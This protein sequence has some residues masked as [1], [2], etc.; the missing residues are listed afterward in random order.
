M[1]GRRG[2][3]LF[4]ATLLLALV[5]V[6]PGSARDGGRSTYVVVL[7]DS[8]GS[9]PAVARDHANRFGGDLRFIYT[10]ALKGYA[11]TLPDAAAA[12]LAHL[13]GVVSVEQDTLYTADTT[14]TP[15]TWGLDRIDQR[16]RPLSNSYT[17]TNTGAGVTAY[18]VDTGIRLTHAEFGGRAVSGYDA[19]TAGGT[20]ADCNGH[21]THVSGTVGGSTYG[22]AK[23]VRLV[24]VRV[25]D[26]NGS[27]TTAQVVAGIDWVTGDHQAGQPAVANMSLGGG[28][29]TAIDTAVRNSIADG[30]SVA[31]SAGIG[32][33]WLFD[34][35]AW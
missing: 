35:Y 32:L 20:A 21:G 3:G 5:V 7:A 33:L 13:P 23:D 17:Y 18:I 2:F 14:E 11:I 10:H 28:A 19:V 34:Q 8:V 25:L 9:V 26:C 6:G 16:S 27:G 15:V 4:L 1:R 22:V 31:N 24:A 12:G 30:V 29:S